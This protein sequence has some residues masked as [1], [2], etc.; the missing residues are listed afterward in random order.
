MEG[1]KDRTTRVR[2]VLHE[3][4]IVDITVPCVKVLQLMLQE[5]IGG[6]AA[7]K[8]QLLRLPALALKM[9]E[10]V[11]MVWLVSA[12]SSRQL[13]NKYTCVVGHES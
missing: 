10:Y 5:E 13:L 8:L 9:E 11:E 6:M 3:E 1:V 7:A 12:C 2:A 4:Q